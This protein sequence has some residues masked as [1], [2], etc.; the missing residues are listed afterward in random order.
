MLSNFFYSYISLTLFIVGLLSILPKSN[1]FTAIELYVR[2]CVVCV[3]IMIFGLRTLE[4]GPDTGAYRL[5]FDGYVYGELGEFSDVGFLFLAELVSLFTSDSKV[6]VIIIFLLQLLL[7]FSSFQVLR[8]KNISFFLIVF[9]F[10]MPGFDLISNT[11]RQGLSVSFGFLALAFYLR[12]MITISGVLFLVSLSI[13]VSSAVFL[14]LF[15]LNSAFWEKTHKTLL[16]A[17]LIVFVLSNFFNA[18]VAAF[19]HSLSIPGVGGALINKLYNY[20]AYND[21]RLSGIYKVYFFL[22]YYVPAFILLF[23]KKKSEKIFS[24]RHASSVLTFYLVILFIYALI[25]KGTFSFRLLYVIYP[26]LIYILTQLYLLKGQ[27]YRVVFYCSILFSGLLVLDSS[28]MIY[29]TFGVD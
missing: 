26:I 15:F 6:F 24:D 8:V 7:I 12:N 3:F 4:S 22:I 16:V 11:V 21:G 27:H 9:V 29:F 14:L 20:E 28:Q 23:H 2:F 18:S 19:L 1:R 25:S 5:F 10:L 13:H 17:I